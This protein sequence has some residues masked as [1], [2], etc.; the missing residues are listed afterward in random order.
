VPVSWSEL[1]KLVWNCKNS[2]NVFDMHN[3]MPD[4]LQEDHDDFWLK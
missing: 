3:V 2:S 1:Y 4:S